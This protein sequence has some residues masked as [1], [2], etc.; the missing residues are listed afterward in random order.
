TRRGR[1]EEVTPP[2]LGFRSWE[3]CC[4]RSSF[5]ERQALSSPAA[6]VF[7]GVGA[8]VSRCTRAVPFGALEP[9]EPLGTDRRRGSPASV[10]PL[11]AGEAG[12]GRSKPTRFRSLAS[13]A[14]EDSVSG[15]YWAGRPFW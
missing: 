2:A 6:G 14:C 4:Q 8:G 11:A 12:P 13:P 10:S 5:A 1:P 3:A 9:L 15:A 7:R